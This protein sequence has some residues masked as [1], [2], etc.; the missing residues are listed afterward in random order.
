MGDLNTIEQRLVA[1]ETALADYVFRYGM[2]DI[3]RGVLTS[4]DKCTKVIAL[5]ETEPAQL[6]RREHST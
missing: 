2:T 6:F 5:G 1:L 4:S 3:A